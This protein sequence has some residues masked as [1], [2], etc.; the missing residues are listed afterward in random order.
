[1]IL[2]RSWLVLLVELE[3]GCELRDKSHVVATK[4]LMQLYLFNIDYEI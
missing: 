1:M 2:G 3:S 4:N